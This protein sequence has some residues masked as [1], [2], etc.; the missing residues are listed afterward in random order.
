MLSIHES[1]FDGKL[2]QRAE[3][4]VLKDRKVLL[5][6]SYKGR[7]AFP[8]GAVDPG[9]DPRGAAIRETLEEVGVAVH[10]VQPLQ[11]YEFDYTKEIGPWHTLPEEITKWNEIGMKTYPFVGEFLREDRRRFGVEGDGRGFVWLTHQEAVRELRTTNTSPYA[12]IRVPH[13]IRI[14]DDLH[15]RGLLE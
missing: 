15:R 8:G 9:E 13:Q 10:H 2:R 1:V 3:M 12:R 14:L 4:Y 5:G 11:P 6:K 7:V